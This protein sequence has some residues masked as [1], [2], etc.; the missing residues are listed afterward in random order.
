MGT[1]SRRVLL[2]NLAAAACLALA[3]APSLAAVR[4]VSAT[5][6]KVVNGAGKVVV[7]N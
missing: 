2:A 1:G 5:P 3:A 7:E 4:I 6:N